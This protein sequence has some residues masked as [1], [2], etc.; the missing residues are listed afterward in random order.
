MG[1]SCEP[2]HQPLPWPCLPLSQVLRL[3]ARALQEAA[4]FFS[5]SGIDGSQVFRA[6]PQAI[7]KDVKTVEA[8]Y[9]W[10]CET[11]GGKP[12]PLGVPLHGHFRTNFVSL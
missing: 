1:G 2:P 11:F 12:P 9:K 4:S 5:R 7:R 8:R 10:L 6:A 3:E